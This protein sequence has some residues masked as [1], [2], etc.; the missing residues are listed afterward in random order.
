MPI[1][2]RKMRSSFTRGDGK[3]DPDLW[4]HSKDRS[5]G[6]TQRLHDDYIETLT[7]NDT[8]PKDRRVT[9]IIQVVATGQVFSATD[10]FQSVA[11]Q[12][13]KALAGV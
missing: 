11:T 12:N 9:S 3:L 8:V 5:V 13:A 10:E 4:L 7:F 2:G 6:T 1:S